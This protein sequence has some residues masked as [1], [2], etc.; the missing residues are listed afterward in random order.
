M[1]V[2]VGVDLLVLVDVGVVVGVGVDLLVLVD[3]LVLVLVLAIVEAGRRTPDAG[4]RTTTAPSLP[5]P[6]FPNRPPCGFLDVVAA[7]L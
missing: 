4:H 3:V 1:G 5:S 7:V 2:V 6:Q